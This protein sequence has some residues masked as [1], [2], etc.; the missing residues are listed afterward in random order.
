M[1]T[2]HQEPMVNLQIGGQSTPFLI[3]SGA[4]KSVLNTKLAAPSAET[5]AIVGATGKRQIYPFLKDRSCKL[6]KYEVTHKFIYIPS[7]PV[8]LMGRDMLSKMRARLTFEEDGTLEVLFRG[9]TIPKETKILLTLPQEEEW[10]LFTTLTERTDWTTFNIPTVWAEGNP[11]GLAVDIPPVIVTLKA[12]ATP[13]SIPQYPLPRQA[14]IGIHGYLQKLKDNGIIEFCQSPWNSPLLP[15]KKLDGSYRPVQDLRAVNQR[16]VS[17]HP[18]VPNPYTLLSLVPAKAKWYSVLDLKDAF[19]C[20]RLH[21]NSKPIFAFQWEHPDTGQRDHVT[22]SRLPQG[23]CNSPSIFGQALAQDLIPLTQAGNPYGILQYVDDILLATE[24]HQECMEATEKLLKHLDQKGYKVS[25]KKAQL[26]QPEVRYLGFILRDGMR[27]LDLGRKEA[28]CSIPTPTTRKQVRE[29]LGAA[30]FCRLWIPNFAVLAKPLHEA[31]KGAKKDPF[32][33]GEEQ[34]QAFRTLKR[35]LMEA[36]ALGLPDLDKPFTL[37]VGERGGIAVGV[38][39]QLVG[40]WPRPVAYFSKQMD[41][42]VKGWPPC[43][44]AVAAAALLAEESS[45]LTLGQ[46][47]ML[48]SPHAVVTLMEHRG[49]HWMT[50]AKLLKFE[51]ILVDNPNVSLSTCTTLNP[52]TLLPVNEDTRM[53][54]DCLQVMEEVYSSRPDLK[55]KPLPNPDWTLFT[56]GSSFVENGERFAGYAIVT[57]EEKVVEAKSLPKGTSAQKAEL[58]ALAQALLLGEG[59]IVN[60]YTDSKY[61]FLTLQAHGAIYKERGLLTSSG[62][63]IKNSQEILALLDAVWKPKK[64]AVMHCKGH[65]YGDDPVTR[66]NR[67]ADTEARLAAKQNPP[68]QIYYMDIQDMIPEKVSYTKDERRWALDEGAIEQGGLLVLPNNKIYVP[69]ILGWCLVQEMHKQTHLGSTAL[70]TLIDR[71]IFIDG[72]HAMARRAALRC[73][74]CA[75]NNPRAGPLLPPGVQYIGHSPWESIV[76]DFTDMPKV[77]RSQHMLV[78]VC[79]YSGWVDAWATPNEKAEQVSRALL[80]DLIPRAGIPLHI[81]SDNGPS[82]VHKIIQTLAILIG[83][84]WKLHCVY[85]PQSS[86]ITERMNRT[87]KGTIG[88]MCQETGLNWVQILPMAL[89]KIRCTPTRLLGLSPY[90]LVYGRPPLGIKQLRGDLV[91]LGKQELINEVQALGSVLQKLHKYVGEARYPFPFTAL[92][93]F[94][95]GE[96]VWLKDGKITPLA[97]RWKGPYVILLTTPT[98]VKLEGVKPWIHYTRIKRDYTEKDPDWQVL[99]DKDNPLKVTIKRLQ[100]PDGGEDSIAT[101]ASSPGSGGHAPP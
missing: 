26:V 41:H 91:Q 96:S 56:D 16:V 25:K 61:A 99:L 89:L 35:A 101:W 20:I 36:P 18:V 23:Y 94:S 81:G 70:A 38:L 84:K 17:L 22:W 3:D 53:Q 31:T 49:H 73:Q 5:T 12:M 66:G 48:K 37:Y 62:H 7:C 82:F 55:D 86:G 43:L 13:I 77:G 51:S 93:S 19:F 68:E 4:T 47:V 92:H 27:K 52:A 46:P 15:V 97:P 65:Q 58:K 11:P 67:K 24:T 59:K 40:P 1:V 100:V 30:G 76:V 33:W 64:V 45:K 50:N 2:G 88:K 10:R 6:D 34:E 98:A 14:V 95:P 79:T 32:Q 90:E 9:P 57:D 21:Q 8:S 54:H 72:V 63:P 28:V 44:R 80:R 69:A 39:T 29:F 75:R 87:L 71:Q 60:V 74:V 85:R 42:V 83:T 78:S